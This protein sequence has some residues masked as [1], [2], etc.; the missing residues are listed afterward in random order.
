[1]HRHDSEELIMEKT[2]TSISKEDHD[3]NHLQAEQRMH[4]DHYSI[5]RMVCSTR[6]DSKWETKAYFEYPNEDLY[7]RRTALTSPAEIM[8]FLTH[9][10]EGLVYL[11]ENRFVHGD[12]RPEYIFY[13]SKKGRYILLDR[14][15]DPSGYSQAQ[16][17]NLVYENKNI[18]MSPEMF[19]Q[20]TRG[21]SKVEHNPFKSEVFTLGMVLLSMFTDDIDLGMCYNRGSKQFD[22][23]HFNSIFKDLNKHFFSGKIER[24]ISDFLVKSMLHMDPKERLSPRKCLHKLR[25]EVA[26]AM[27]KEL[28]RHQ[29]ELRM[30][31][32]QAEILSNEGTNPSETLNTVSN[33]KES[34]PN[35]NVL[36]E[37]EII[38]DSKEEGNTGLPKPMG[39]KLDLENEGF[40]ESNFYNTNGEESEIQKGEKEGESGLTESND[41]RGINFNSK[42]LQ[43]EEMKDSESFFEKGSETNEMF[44]SKVEIDNSSRGMIPIEAN[45]KLISEESFDLRANEIIQKNFQGKGWIRNNI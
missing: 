25:Y 40:E 2:R 4:I 18:F 12:I 36:K 29:M 1:M 14:L 3:F 10:L 44:Q 7:D 30:K 11:Q 31:D 21:S 37:S 19:F 45:S 13:D 39:L 33:S 8:K 20:L 43:S 5:L 35:G 15:G 23:S 42:E 22:F 38:G 9:L 17:N 34:A 32:Q 6:D 24:L 27:L 41:C 16:Q 26:P 28:E